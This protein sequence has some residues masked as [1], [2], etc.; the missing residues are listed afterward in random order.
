MEGTS[1]ELLYHFNQF[2]TH[3]TFLRFQK[4]PEN[5]KNQE[6]FKS[7]IKKIDHYALLP[8]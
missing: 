2:S 5:P 6:I 4:I 7:T 1:P 8:N 3:M